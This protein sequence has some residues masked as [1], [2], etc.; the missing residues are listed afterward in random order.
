MPNIEIILHSRRLIW[1]FFL[2]DSFWTGWW[3]EPKEGLYS[4][5]NDPSNKERIPSSDF[6][7]ESEPNGDTRENCAV[8]GSDLHYFYDHFCGTLHCGICNIGTAPIFTI[9]G[10]CTESGFDFHYGWDGIVSGNGK[11]FFRGFSKSSMFWDAKNL[12]WRLKDVSNPLLYA[13][14]NSTKGPYPFGTH[15]WY[16]FN[17]VGCGNGNVSEVEISFTS[18]NEDMFNCH[19]G[20]W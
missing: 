3:D 20:T 9:R 18:C 8:I 5:I 15:K 1:P 2:S 11:I 4:D 14:N 7:A 13:I 12:N 10:L 6:W 17:D 16:V 19:D